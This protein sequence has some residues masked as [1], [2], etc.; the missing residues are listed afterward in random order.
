MTA[1]GSTCALAGPA[2]R[3][4]AYDI[5][6]G[7]QQGRQR[8]A[9]QHLTH[10]HTAASAMDSAAETSPRPN[11]IRRK[12]R[13][14]P[15]N[16]RR[17][18]VP[19]GTAGNGGARWRNIF[20]YRKLGGHS[21]RRRE[22]IWQCRIPFNFKALAEAL[23]WRGRELRLRRDACSPPLP[24]C[25]P[26][27]RR[28]RALVAAHARRRSPPPRPS[29][30]RWCF[31]DVPPTEALRINAAIPFSAEPNPARRLARLP[32]RQRPATSCARSSASPRPSITRPARR[33]RTAS[34]PSPRSCSTGSATR[35]IRAASAE[36]SIRGRCAPAAAASSPSP[37]TA[38]SRRRRPAPAGS[39]PAASPPKR[40]P[41]PST[42]RSASPPT[43]TPIRSLPD[44]AFRL[45]KAAVIG[46]H[47]FYRMPGAWGGAAAFSQAYRG[48]EPS[49]ATVMAARLPIN[50]GRARGAALAAA[51]DLAQLAL[52]PADRS[53]HR[54]HRSAAARRS[55]TGCRSRRS[56]PSSRIAAAGSA[57]CRRRP[58]P[59]RPEF[60]ARYSIA[61]SRAPKASAAADVV[62]QGDVLR[63]AAR[64][65][66]RAAIRR[67]SGGSNWR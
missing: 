49:P 35:P 23:R 2:R 56:G 51:V 59:D 46:N 6:A 32:R 21:N 1:L 8:N 5:A 12:A 25:R 30:S 20:S 33:A 65:R 43:T 52:P 67:R 60:R 19:L 13:A 55:T 29:P 53:G 63:G 62:E 27:R 24:A 40:S 11:T 41:A 54:R 37:A 16:R 18:T 9:R 45:A 50:L 39:A 15:L 38:R 61:A 66:A 10:L 28:A 7:G 48:R 58:L 34:A 22:A 57:T 14:Q 17:S 31:A 3:S 44:W 26:G 47:I 4:A 36:S 64:C 42:R